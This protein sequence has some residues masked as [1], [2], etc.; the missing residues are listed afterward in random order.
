M[1]D[2]FYLFDAL[3][4]TRQL[5]NS[6]GAVSDSYLFDAFGNLLDATGSSVNPFRFGGQVG[7]Y[8]DLD[9]QEYYLRARQYVPLIGRFLSRDMILLPQTV[10]LYNYGENSPTNFID[11]SGMNACS[12]ADQNKCAAMCARKYRGKQIIPICISVTV[13][14]VVCSRTQIFCYCNANKFKFKC[15]YYECKDGTIL[16]QRKRAEIDCPGLIVTPNTTCRFA[17]EQPGSCPG[18]N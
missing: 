5:A 15:C 6:S 11:P 16:H 4:S 14:L 9:L 8:E 1:V 2:S 18:E 13:W 10:N 7:Y 3:G 17:F 12:V